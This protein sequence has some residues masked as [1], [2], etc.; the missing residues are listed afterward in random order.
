VGLGIPAFARRSRVHCPYCNSRLRRP[1]ARARGV[2]LLDLVRWR[3]SW[4]MRRFR[5][6]AEPGRNNLHSTGRRAGLC[7]PAMGSAAV[8]S[9]TVGVVV[10]RGRLSPVRIRPAGGGD[11]PDWTRSA[12]VY[13]H[14]L[15]GASCCR[16][17]TRAPGNT[18]DGAIPR[19]GAVPDGSCRFL[20]DAPIPCLP[21]YVAVGRSWVS[22]RF[23]GM[24]PAL[25]R[26][27]RA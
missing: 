12:R 5:S 20:A 27:Y 1:A 21:S 24:A 9:A 7:Q 8:L 2:A 3:I 25:R 16:I 4:A 11:C 18:A 26:I 13:S 6:Y 15:R 23:G 19:H 14:F 10:L 17:E 22:L